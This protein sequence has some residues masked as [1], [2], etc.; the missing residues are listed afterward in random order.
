M[1]QEGWV[2]RETRLQAFSE[3]WVLIDRVQAG[4]L[5]G[6]L[7][8]AVC[9]YLSWLR[10]KQAT[11]EPQAYFRLEEDAER[12]WAF[13]LTLASLDEDPGL[14]WR[15]A[16]LDRRFEVLRFLLTE[17]APDET[18]RRFCQLAIDG[19][20]PIHPTATATQGAPIQW[21]DAALTSQIHQV[22]QPIEFSTLAAHFSTNKFLATTL[23]K[24]SADRREVHALHAY[25]CEL[26]EYYRAAAM[27]RCGTLVLVD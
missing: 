5:S 14:L 12:K 24:K 16:F 11:T 13:E 9:I 20:L 23:Y 18:S 2:G 21:S 6:D 17:S 8:Q 15:Q 10:G 25:F 22:L 1:E 3:N 27:A 4:E 7:L 19:C 26:K